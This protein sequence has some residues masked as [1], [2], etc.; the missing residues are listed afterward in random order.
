MTAASQSVDLKQLATLQK[1]LDGVVSE[2]AEVEE[3]W[4]E[5]SDTADR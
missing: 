5:T 4:L 3:A 2:L 1:E